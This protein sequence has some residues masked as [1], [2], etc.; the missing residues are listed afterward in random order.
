MMKN[1]VLHKYIGETSRSVYERAWEHMS[2]MEGLQTS[3][4]M[5][6]HALEKHNG[7]EDLEKIKF[8]VKVLRFTRNAFERQVT[9]SVMIQEHRHH[10]ILNSKSEYNRCSLPRLTANLGDREWRKRAKEEKEEKERE[11]ELER[12]IVSMRKNRN[13]KRRDDPKESEEPAEKR[14]RTGEAEWKRVRQKMECGEKRKDEETGAEE[15]GEPANKRRKGN[16]IRNHFAH[17]ERSEEENQEEKED[18]KAQ[19]PT[20]EEKERREDETMPEQE[21]LEGATYGN[22]QDGEFMEKDFWEKF[23]EEKRKRIE[24]DEK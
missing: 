3:S 24:K 18:L 11:Q 23:L 5:L 9:E 8:G 4:H 2:S 7:E 13:V 16:D 19:M 10:N 21:E 17:E 22:W 14:R 15:K 6:K 12:K 1:I 20:G